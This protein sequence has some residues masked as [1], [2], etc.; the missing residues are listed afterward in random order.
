MDTK[1]Q[2]PS[3]LNP[4]LSKAAQ[5]AAGYKDP[6]D[7]AEY[8][9]AELSTYLPDA[10]ALEGR[11]TIIKRL[12]LGY[13][14]QYKP[15][16]E[17]NDLSLVQTT[18]EDLMAFNTYQ[19]NDGDWPEGDTTNS[20]RSTAIRPVERNKVMSVAGHAAGRLGFLKLAAMDEGSVPQED[21]A[22]VLNSLM[23]WVRCTWFG[24]EQLLSMVLASLYAPKC[25]AHIEFSE[26]YRPHKTQKVNGKWGYEFR[27][28]ED[29]SGFRSTVVPPDQ[30]FLENVFERDIQK[31]GW[32]IWRRVQSFS[33][34]QAKYS[35]WNNWDKVRPGM[36]LVFN[37]P[38]ANF[39]YVYDPEMWGD[40]QE[41]IVMW[42]KNNG[43]CMITMVGGVVLGEP[44]A[45]NPREDGLYPFAAWGYQM[46]RTNFLY[47]KSLVSSVKQDAK[48]LNT[49]YPLIIDGAV[50]STIPPTVATGTEIIGTDVIIPGVTTTLKNKD[51]TL[52]PIMAPPDI[53][54]AMA[55][56][57]EVEKSLD[58]TVNVQ[59]IPQGGNNIT[60]YQISVLEQQQEEVMGPFRDS[61][62][63]A[64]AQLTRL[65]MG[66]VLQ[67][68]TAVDASKVTGDAPLVYRTFLTGTG[69]SGGKGQQKRIRFE[70]FGGKPVDKLKESYKTLKEQGG[71][72]SSVPLYRV[73]P[74]RFRDL[75]FMMVMSDDVL[76]SK[77]E[78]VRFTRNLETFDKAIEAKQAGANVDLDAMFADFVLSGNE[79][80][81]RNPERYVQANNAAPPLGQNPLAAIQGGQNMMPKPP[82]PQ[83][84]S[85]R[86]PAMPSRPR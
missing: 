22:E 78:N 7:K 85:P 42:D 51:A 17:F 57:G 10:L 86:T 66:D 54:K 35:M 56:L 72:N 30:I 43:G 71:A 76:K 25:F 18:M 62:L 29:M 82:M 8:P 1:T 36:H 50:L 75:K 23:D 16:V 61:L 3:I 21:A 26:V 38:N 15:R 77:S 48:V 84:S 33:L 79:R 69:K 39:Y 63:A 2:G 9:S 70:D 27:L 32:V 73:N 4:I 67:H 11:S 19:P 41:E 5:V 12:T 34:L 46:I 40:V 13:T 52:K 45:K 55:A 20:W 24:P 81:A 83:A 60:A 37:D 6:K 14:N 64:S 44:D 49:L 58:D 28:D 53:A 65:V 59:S 74:T 80:G 47:D 68:F 31:Q